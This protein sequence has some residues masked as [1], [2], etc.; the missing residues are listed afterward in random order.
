MQPPVFHLRTCTR[1][2][3]ASRRGA[4]VRRAVLDFF[5]SL[6]TRTHTFAK[7]LPL[8][9]T[10]ILL[11]RPNIHMLFSTSGWKYFSPFRVSRLFISNQTTAYFPDFDGC[12]RGIAQ[13]ARHSAQICARAICRQFW[14][15]D[16]SSPGKE[17]TKLTRSRQTGGR[18]VPDLPIVLC[19]WNCGVPQMGLMGRSCR[20]GQK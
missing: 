7:P 4:S 1:I 16:C 9:W 15:D 5:H 19:H 18:L 13:R 3:P 10:G 14:S 17:P 11:A 6:R 12:D 2:S 8:G 20:W